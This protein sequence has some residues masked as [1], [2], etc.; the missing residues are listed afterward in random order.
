LVLTVAKV[1]IGNLK[2]VTPKPEVLLAGD[3]SAA[4][5]AS[6]GAAVALAN[7]TGQGSDGLNYSAAANSQFEY[8]LTSVP[9]TGDGAISHRT[10]VVCLLIAFS[11][12]VATILSQLFDK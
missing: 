2:D 3:E 4:D 5:P 11:I 8:L 10:T 12:T 9:K 1:V 7:W 6:I